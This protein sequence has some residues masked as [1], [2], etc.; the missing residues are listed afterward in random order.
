M[1]E[2]LDNQLIYPTAVKDFDAL[3]LF[4]N[5]VSLSNNHVDTKTGFNIVQV[6]SHS[7]HDPEMATTHMTFSEEIMHGDARTV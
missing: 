2:I 3:S 4:P 7:H 6:E 1:A 5:V